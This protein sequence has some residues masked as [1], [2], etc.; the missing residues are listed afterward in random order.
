MTY[1]TRSFSDNQEAGTFISTI[2]K[3]GADDPIGKSA[4]NTYV[5]GYSRSYAP[6]SRFTADAEHG[7]GVMYSNWC[8]SWRNPWTVNAN[9]L[10]RL[11]S[12]AAEAIR[13]HDFNA[14]LASV[15]A[16]ESLQTV[17]QTFQFFYRAYK[18]ARKGDWG[19]FTYA[20]RDW[21][22]G[23][24]AYAKQKGHSVLTPKGRVY[25]EWYEKP[26]APARAGD[27]PGAILNFN[28]ALMPMISDI[29][30][31]W[32]AFNRKVS[33]DD[34]FT[35][36]HGFRERGDIGNGPSGYTELG[37]MLTETIVRTQ[38]IVVLHQKMNALD[39]YGLTDLPS[40]AYEKV[41]LSWLLD[42]V[43]PIGQYLQNMHFYRSA[44]YSYCQTVHFKRRDRFIRSSYPD[45]T[46]GPFPYQPTVGGVSD[47]KARCDGEYGQLDRTHG[48]SL[49]IPF[50][51]VKSLSKITTP[52]HV[53]N[54]GSLIL[55]KLA[56]V[57]QDNRHGTI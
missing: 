31:A 25:P 38:L 47:N 39:S 43:I 17:V 27:V 12:K 4:F 48:S 37:Y 15:E 56:G 36:R 45:N 16:K 10:N 41:P 51:G 6:K 20:Y 21:A 11:Y 14:G 3:Q 26:T 52:T 35:I 28:L 13:G 53:L 30:A 24:Q 1:Y 34:R 5:C 44:S 2:Y 55:S 49:A 40:M 9:T 23:R 22:T 46:W 57:H 42:Y 32:E 33:T 29:W 8:Y 18:A 19:G 7:G 50:P 54:A